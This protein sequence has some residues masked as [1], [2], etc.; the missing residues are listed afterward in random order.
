MDLIDLIK[1]GENKILEFKEQLPSNDRIVKTVIAFSNTAGGRLVVGVNDSC[2]IV[3]INEN[4]IFDLQDRIASIIFDNCY[5]NILP[6]IYTINTNGKLLLVIEVYRG[7][8]L[9]YY[10]KNEGK[11]NGTYIRIGATNRKAEFDYIIDLERHR[12]H[13]SYD[14]DLNY[15]VDFMSID[16]SNLKKQFLNVGKFLDITKMKN[17]RLIKE[18]NG[19]IYPTNALL[20]LTGFYPHCSI[21]CGRFK[22]KTMDLFI[23]RKEY[24][25]DI[26]TIFENTLNFIL[27]HLNLKGEILGIRR[28]DTYEVP[29][30]ALRESLINALIHRD[31][32][33][34]GRDIKVGV[35]DDIVNIVS[36]G[37]FPGSITLQDIELGRSDARN[38]IV[39]AVFKE[40]ELIEQWGSGIKRIKSAC[41]EIGL[42]EPQIVEKNDYV[43]VEIYRPADF[44][45]NTDN[46][47]LKSIKPAESSSKPAESSSKPA[48]SSSEPAESDS[49]P[50][51]S[52]SKP[53]E[54]DSK[55]A[56]SEV[57]LKKIESQFYQVLNYLKTHE[58]LTTQLAEKLLNVKPSRAREVLYSMVQKNLVTKHGKGKNTYYRI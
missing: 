14:E 30:V 33:N 35:Y 47:G 25:G 56:E 29:V 9:P 36:P 51:E 2:E 39:S 27:N 40:L 32:I 4:N 19:K 16:I 34:Q 42:Q 23:D 28:T 38:K 53:A 58:T 8:L 41:K 3:G 46:G 17:L 24:S 6:E 54:S 5:P 44:P 55:P 20:I 45:A 52:D 1:L 12:R 22:G 49:K 48:E 26:F 15:D 7:N 18:D 21:K 11:N 43:D 10:Q 13:L 57:V 31:Y 37:G 50:A